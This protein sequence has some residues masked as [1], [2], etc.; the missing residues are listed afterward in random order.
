MQLPT[1]SV[2]DVL[3]TDGRLRSAFLLASRGDRRFVQVHHAPGDNRL[4]WVVAGALV[5]RALVSGVPR[6]A[7][8]AST[9]S[10]AASTA[11]YAAGRSGAV[12]LSPPRAQR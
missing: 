2:V 1:P 3:C 7:S 5:D 4:A 10:A 12:A 9:A 8:T 11:A 6:S